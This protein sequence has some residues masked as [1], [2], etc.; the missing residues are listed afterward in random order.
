MQSA[1]DDEL[2]KNATYGD[3]MFNVLIEHLER[4]RSKHGK[5]RIASI[6]A[7]IQ[8]DAG[9]AESLSAAVTDGIRQYTDQFEA[10]FDRGVAITVEVSFH[11][12]QDSS[13]QSTSK[14]SEDV[15]SLIAR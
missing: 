11:S 3:V 14:C 6:S 8:P 15:D 7:S 12:D 9:V 10:R 4:L 1:W 2:E 13:E 5:R